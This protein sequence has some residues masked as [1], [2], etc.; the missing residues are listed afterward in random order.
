METRVRRWSALAA[1]FIVLLPWPHSLSAQS[2]ST[3]D[4]PLTLLEALQSTLSSQPQLQIQQQQV[5]SSRALTQEARGQFDTVTSSTF[6]FFRV[7]NPLTLLGQPQ[8]GILT[9]DLVTNFTTLEVG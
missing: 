6:S 2:P 3:S 5:A 8:T 7:D 4:A 9:H 1:G